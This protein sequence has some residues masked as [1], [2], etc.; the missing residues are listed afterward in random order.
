MSIKW[1][2]ISLSVVGIF[3]TAAAVIGVVQVQQKQVNERVSDEMAL[4]AKSETE[5]IARDV[6]LMLRTHN[7]AVKHKVAYDLNVARYVVQNKGDVTFTDDTVSWNA[8]NQYTK[9]AATVN[10]PKMTIGGE[11]LGQNSDI[12]I[13]SPV[14]DEVKKLVGGTCTI[15]QR[16]NPDGDMLR[17]CTNVE[18]LDG[19]RA[20]GTYIPAVNP[21][22]KPNPVISTVLKGQTFHG[23]AY[24]VNAW[25]ITAYEPIYD[26]NNQIAGVLYVGVKQES[27]DEL[28]ESIM[29]I[30]VGKT[31][32]VYIL[33]GKGDQQGHYIISK[34]GKRDGENIW[35]A[36]DA[37]DRLFIQSL[38]NKAIAT[39]GGQ[40]DFEWYPWKN[41]GE[42]KARIKVAAV[43]YFEPWDWVIG[44]GAYEDDYKDAAIDVNRALNALT[45]WSMVGAG[46]AV[47]LAGFIASFF[48]GRITKSIHYVRLAINDIA[49]GD[50]DLTKRLEVNT[51]DEVGLLAQGFNSFIEKIHRI[52]SDVAQASSE[53]ASGATE[54]AASSEQMAS[55][56]TEQTQQ[57]TR[58]SAAIEQMSSSVV[59]VARK[60]A[61]AA[62]NAAESGKVAEQGG[63]VVEQ[64]I[65][66]MNQISEAVTASA[67]SVQNLGKRGEQIGEIIEVIN[68]IADQTNLLALNAAIEAARAG[69]HGR[70]FAVVADE[71]RKLADRTTQATQEV[72]ES[73]QAIQAETTQAVDK[74]NAGTEQVQHGVALAQQAG[75]S[76]G[77]IVHTAR[78]VAGLVESIA[79][80]AE[81]QSA[82]SE[83]I[84]RNIESITAVTQQTNE[85]ATQAAE[86]AGQLS[87]KAEQL[88]QIV[89]QF[90]L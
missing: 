60:S 83:E 53:V 50:G 88:M 74:M 79:A 82:S 68:D 89:S 41:Q 8:V 2:I 43:T 39:R 86:A 13:A 72:A 7:E 36:R 17:V 42:T 66:G 76:L 47:L 54:I 58:I 71:V 70:G 16:M 20:T 67:A 78:N 48:A 4:L 23:R 5:K 21:D 56:M 40:C 26:A 14:V 25:Y 9:K 33:G 80:A 10:L 30:T 59:E 32:Y 22:G 63:Q 49:Q 51:H 27:V 24:V 57:V 3:I 35:Q 85:G 64:T 90:K 18:K 12:H 73:I 69:E 75:Q 31:G 28:R 81:Q 65:D 38:I 15:F 62:G 55:G 46:V 29:D 77:E 44:A 45:G 1:K 11:W 52:I 84:G 34:D 87:R 61:E 19:T 37:D 6:W